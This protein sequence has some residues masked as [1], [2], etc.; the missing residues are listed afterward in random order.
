MHGGILADRDRPRAPRRH[1]EYGIEPIDLV[2]ANLYPFSADPSIELI[3]IGGP[4]MVRA[5]AKN[6]A[7]VGV[8]ID[9]A[10]YDGVLAELRA[11][12]RAV[13]RPPAPT[14]PR[15]VRRTPPPTTPQIVE[16]LTPSRP[17]RRRRRRR[18]D[19]RRP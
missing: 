16:W 12:R 13:S 2:V 8:V 14:G 19:D 6:H 3:D 5:A 15:R 18:G 1:G 11:D 17:R 10:D 9:P 4:T 7:F